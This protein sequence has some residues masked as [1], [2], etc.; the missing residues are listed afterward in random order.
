MGL[1][2]N[3]SNGADNYIWVKNNGS[4]DVDVVINHIYDSNNNDCNVEGDCETIP[5]GETLEIGFCIN[6][7]GAYVTSKIL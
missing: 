2:I 4:S 3:C 1:T 6:A 5:A 7:D